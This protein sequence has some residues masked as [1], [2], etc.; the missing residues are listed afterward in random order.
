MLFTLVVATLVIAAQAPQHSPRYVVPAQPVTGHKA[1]PPPDT[2]F[3]KLFQVPPIEKAPERSTPRKPTPGTV[4]QHG[5]V[6]R[7]PCNMPIITA[8]AD[9]DPKILVPIPEHAK[10]SAKIRAIEPPKCK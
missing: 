9:V 2:P 6:E 7:G 1:P 4:K 8:N 3:G 10:K 5:G